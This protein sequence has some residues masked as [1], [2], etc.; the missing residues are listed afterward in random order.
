[1][2]PVLLSLLLSLPTLANTPAELQPLF[3]HAQYQQLL[4]KI[5]EQPNTE[6]DPAIS[7]LQARALIQQQQ[8]E[9]ANTLLNELII[10]YPEHSAILTTAA[11]N[12]LVLASSGSVFNARKRATDALEL[13]H[14]AIE[15]DPLN[16][17]AQQSLLNFYQ[18]APANAGGSKELAAE[19]AAAI[20]LLDPVQGALAQATIAASDTRLKDA[21]QLIERQL[22]LTP[23]QP[24][25]LLRKAALLSQQSAFLVAQETYLQ[26]LP[27]LTDPTQRYS[28]LFQIGRLG[29][30]TKEY[31][32]EA[33]SALEQ[34]LAFYQDSQQPR[35]N[36]ARLRLAQLYLMQG[37]Q[38]KAIELYQLIANIESDEQDFIEARAELANKLAAL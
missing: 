30:F 25:L 23:E 18:T 33:I 11:L 26:A 10:A 20:Q 36:R 31:Q 19:R 12:K 16:F 3:D 32:G 14:K 8:R 28:T 4:Q 2:K 34:Y 13:L 24:E 9:A 7:L 17:Q 15:H 29:V 22:Q 1:M 6:P 35:L 5:A 27:L 38:G 37:N 21:L